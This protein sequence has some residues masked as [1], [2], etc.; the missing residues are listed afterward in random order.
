MARLIDNG[1]DFKPVVYAKEEHTRKKI[2]QFFL[3]KR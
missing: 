3:E 2:Y 1:T